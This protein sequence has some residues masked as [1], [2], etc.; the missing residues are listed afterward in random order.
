M[1]L[2]SRLVNRLW[3]ITLPRL[4]TLSTITGVFRGL[5]LFA[6]LFGGWPLFLFLYCQRHAILLAFLSLLGGSL[7]AEIG[8]VFRAPILLYAWLTLPY[9]LV[10]ALLIRRWCAAP[11]NSDGQGI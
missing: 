10:L 3:W 2:Q 8:V 5:I 11:K 6:F 9:G 4:Q 1:M 7:V